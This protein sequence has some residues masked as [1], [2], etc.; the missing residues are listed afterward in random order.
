MCEWKIVQSFGKYKVITLCGSTRFKDEFL[1]VEREL[2]KQNYIVINLGLFSKSD[3]KN[4]NEKLPTKEEHIDVHYQKIDMCDGI[5]V[6]NVD[7]Y[8]GNSTLREI[9]YATK[10]GKKIFYLSRY[11][12]IIIRKEEW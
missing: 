9:E 8:I 2:A 11:P 10:S 1:R 4:P 6:V 5:F 7:G 12:D 3:P